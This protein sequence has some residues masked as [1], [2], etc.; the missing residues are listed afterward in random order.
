MIVQLLLYSS[1]L[2]SKLLPSR[3]QK[4][5]TQVSKNITTNDV[6]KS[7]DTYKLEKLFFC[8]PILVLFDVENDEETDLTS[9]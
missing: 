9:D 3:R 4:K 5:S 2:V 1:T 8:C 7:P 6:T